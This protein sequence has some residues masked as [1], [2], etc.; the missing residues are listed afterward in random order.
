LQAA[1]F[2]AA[3]LRAAAA[4]FTSFLQGVHKFLQKT[5]DFLL[6]SG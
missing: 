1:G 5:L 3:F 6:A 4:V 2:P